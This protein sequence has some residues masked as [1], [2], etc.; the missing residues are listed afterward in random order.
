MKIK[1]LSITAFLVSVLALLALIKN[2][3][4][5]ASSPVAITIQT[6]A[7]L[8]MIWAR[9]TFGFR[10]FHA[11][12]NPTSGKLITN[13]P[14]KYIRHPI[15]AVVVVFT[16]V[17]VVTNK[18][19]LNGILGLLIVAGMVTRALYEERLLRERYPDYADYARRTWRM[20]PFVF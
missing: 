20:I 5:F 19:P 2:R 15:Y 18:S 12:A 16:L 6:L 9:V 14:Y 13:G 10:S 1:L 11:A 17:G 7:I 3:G 4:L 8:L